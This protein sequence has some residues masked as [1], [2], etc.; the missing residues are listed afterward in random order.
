MKYKDYYS[1][2]GVERTASEDDI[3]KAYRKLAKKYHPDVSKESNAEE[4]F[5]E[6]VEAYATLKD[7]EKRAAYDQLGSHPSGQECRPPPYWWRQ[8][9]ESQSGF[10]NIGLG[11]LFAALAGGHGRRRPRGDIRIPGEDYEVAIHITLEQAFHRAEIALEPSSSE[12]LHHGF[13]YRVRPKLKV[14]TPPGAP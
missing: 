6:I 3:K 4:K 13:M 11:D 12:Y 8:C 7:K 9:G 14:L 5:N 1:I 10:E 2:L